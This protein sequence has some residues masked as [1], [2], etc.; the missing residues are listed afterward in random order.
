MHVNQ[1]PAG[2]DIVIRRARADEAA[3]FRSLRLRA[4][5]DAPTAF[6]TTLAEAEAMPAEYWVGRVAAGAAGVANAMLVAVESAT[7]GPG[8]SPATDRWVGMMVGFRDEADTTLGHVVSVW[9]APEARRLGVARRLLDAVHTWAREHG[10]RTL[11]LGVTSD[12]VPA[13]R[14]YE[15]AGYRPTGHTF[16]LPS[17]PHLHEITMEC[18]L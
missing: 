11:R 14:L 2:P 15:Q 7:E 10:L 5:A 4:L 17:H 9:V 6:A 12:N 8:G 16:P 1:A 13:R 18:T 3:A